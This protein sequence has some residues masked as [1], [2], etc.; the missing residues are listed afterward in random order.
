MPI[1]LMVTRIIFIPPIQQGQIHHPVCVLLWMNFPW[2]IIIFSLPI[3]IEKN[4]P[5]DTGT[6]IT[7]YGGSSGSRS[8]ASSFPSFTDN[9]NHSPASL[10]FGD[11]QHNHL[12]HHLHHHH[13][14]PVHP[15]HAVHHHNRPLKPY[16]PGG[17]YSWP[18]T[19]PLSSR[20]DSPLV[21]N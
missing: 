21:I 5:M 15:N 16:I 20:S 9:N 4:A 8:S 11:D 6:L 1:Q 2:S 14:H 12:A 19:R 13:H 7:R 18:G 10:N 17:I 3:L